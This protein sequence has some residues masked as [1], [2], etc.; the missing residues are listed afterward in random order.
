MQKEI[1]LADF[2][3]GKADTY[4][5]QRFKP[6]ELSDHYKQR[7]SSSRPFTEAGLMAAAKTSRAIFRL[8]KKYI[9]LC[10]DYRQQTRQD[11]ITAEDVYKWVTVQQRVDDLDTELRDLFRASD[12][13]LVVQIF[14][15]LSLKGQVSQRELTSQSF[16]HS[17]SDETKASRL[18]SKLEQHG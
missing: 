13:R 17:D 9:R 4:E 7:F 2:F 16:G 11:S 12:R 5:I 10:L 15:V 18:L 6:Q 8:F 14:D 1:E 3:L